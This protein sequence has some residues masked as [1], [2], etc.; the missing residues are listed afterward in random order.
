M[1]AL[2]FNCDGAIVDSERDGH[3]VAFNEAFRQMGINVDWPVDLY[4]SLL[5]IAGGKER[6]RYYF[7]IYGWPHK[8][9]DRERLIKELHEQK[10]GSYI[11]IIKDGKIPLRTGVLRLIDEAIGGGMLVAICS[12]SNEQ[13]VNLLADR[14]LGETRKKHIAGIFAGDMVSMKKPDPEIY[15]LASRHLKVDPRQCVVIEDSRIGLLAATGAGMHCV[16]TKSG[17][18]QNEDFFE[19]DAVYSELGDPP[20][21]L[22]TLDTL[23][24]IK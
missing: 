22:V 18:T 3:R 12:A 5:K 10:T 1:K 2:I 17:Y 14:M 4:G 9:N 16:I 23:K 24:C 11:K 13:A 19:A 20:A 15:N 6:L 7:D 8:Y 21:E